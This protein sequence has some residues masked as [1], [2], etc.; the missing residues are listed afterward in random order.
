MEELADLQHVIDIRA[1]QYARLGRVLYKHLAGLTDP[2]AA[3]AD[4]LL[5]AYLDG[6]KD[7]HARIDQQLAPL[8]RRAG[9]D[10]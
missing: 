6:L 2:G 8:F 10:P 3:I 7:M 4:L 1:A 5:D 9:I